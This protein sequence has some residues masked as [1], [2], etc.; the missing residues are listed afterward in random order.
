MN[1]TVAELLQASQGSLCIGN[2]EKVVEK[3][4]T[5]TRVLKPGEAFLAL[6]GKNFN[7]D[8]FINEAFEKGASG[9]I[10]SS[11]STIPEIP[12]GCFFFQVK[13]TLV[14]LGEIAREWRRVVDPTVCAL[15]GSSGKTTTKEMIAYI[16]QQSFATHATE[17][18]FNNRI[19]LPLTLLKLREEHELA[20]IETGMNMSGELT[21]LSEI[22]I[23]DIAVITNIGNAHIGNFGSVENLIRAKAELFEAMP[24]EGTAIVNADCPHSSI[25]AEAFDIPEMVISYGQN[26]KADVQAQDVELVEP[27]GYTFKL[28]IL[29]EVIPMRLNVFGRFQVSNALAAAAAAATIGVAP[30]KIA[31]RLCAFHAPSMRAHTEWFDGVFIISDCYNASP[32]A[33]ITALRSLNDIQGLNQRFAVLGDML[34]LGEHSHKYHRAVGEAVAEAHI[35]FLCTTGVWS[36]LIREEAENRGIAAKQFA[37]AEEIAEFLDRKLKP[38]DAL[39]VKGSRHMK[40]EEVLV[41]FRERRS[42]IREGVLSPDLDLDPVGDET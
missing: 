6:R 21:M 29:D 32:D 33:T 14:A 23:P 38:N 39:I 20:V 41:K 22:C 26:P 9:V 11:D 31:E 7:G 25:M 37:S 5:D 40:L 30:E 16:C 17:G 1:F 19:G 18:N 35:D 8:A 28:K 10:C 24:K 2:P 27:Y 3:I 4:C 15:T 36:E 12:D 13:D 34:E 42:A